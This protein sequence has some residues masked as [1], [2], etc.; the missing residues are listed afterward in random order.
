MSD[1]VNGLIEARQKAWH[2]A[3]EILDRCVEDKRERT[4]E[5]NEMFE[6]ANADIERLG[7]EIS[8]YQRQAEV[9]RENDVFRSAFEGVINPDSDKR[10]SALQAASFERFLRTGDTTGLVADGA[11]AV[12]VDIQSAAHMSRLIRSGMDANEVRALYT[13][14]GSGSLLA[15]TT[16]VRELYQYMEASSAVRQVSRVITTAG[17]EPMDFP[18]VGTHA[19][20][21]QVAAES[22]TLAGTDP[23]FEK[24]TLNAYR[25]GQLVKLSTSFVQDSGVDVEGFIAQ[26]IGRALGRITDTAYVTGGGS[27]APNG[28]VTAAGTGV[29]TGGTLIPLTFDN[30]IDLQHSVVPEYRDGAVWV[31]SDTTA[32][33]LRKIRA[34]AGDTAG[35]I[36]GQYLWEP[37]QQ[38]GRPDT[39]LGNPVYTD[40]NFAS[41]GSA[42]RSVA[43]GNFREAY[44]IR[45]VGGIRLERSTDRYF[46]TDEI[47]YRGIIRTDADLIDLNAIKTSAQQA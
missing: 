6:R 2:D 39:L 10:E 5:E 4:A 33:S 8:D 15:P 23:T 37:S 16:F 29:K 18:K 36:L 20:G 28:V 3:K 24:L 22:T 32:G 12:M 46:D 42:A 1:H 25:Y 19:I 31:M 45:D 9:E 27:T 17:G 38:A 44:I 21:T 11:N 41:Q 14:S 47:G 13:G 43:F 26:N 30:L 40:V 35:T 7:R 34:G